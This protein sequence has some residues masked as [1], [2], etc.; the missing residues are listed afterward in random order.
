MRKG[1]RLVLRICISIVF[2]LIVLLGVV[3]WWAR[4]GKKYINQGRL[5]GN[6]SWSLVWND[7]FDGEELNSEYWKYDIGAGLWGNEEL[8]RYTR[9][10]NLKVSDGILRITA[11]L[12]E[13]KEGEYTSSRIKTRNKVSFYQ[14]RIEASIKLP[15]GK[16][17]WPAFWMMGTQKLGLWSLCGEIDIMEAVNDCRR[18]YGTIHWPVKS[19]AADAIRGY[20]A[21]SKAANIEIADAD[22]WHLYAIE[23]N[24]EQIDW[25]VDDICYS[26]YRFDANKLSEDAFNSPFYLLLNV[27][28][29]GTWAG[30][31][32]ADAYPLTMQVDYVRVYS[33]TEAD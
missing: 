33:W 7:E 18:I 12:S 15:S 16:G 9:G 23:W 10:E 28:V 8:E 26:S 22:D 5:E 6:G 20:A 24:G 13:T 32:N 30:Q 14:G 31:P 27:A 25:Y 1:L 21:Q 19:D 17:V 11:R 3:L 29:G 2:L 4:P